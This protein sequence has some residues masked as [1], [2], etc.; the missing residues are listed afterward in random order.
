MPG[1]SGHAKEHK[2]YFGPFHVSFNIE[3]T[4]YGEFQILLPYTTSASIALMD[5]Y[6]VKSSMEGNMLD[7]VIPQFLRELHHVRS[8]PEGLILDPKMPHEEDSEPL[9]LD[10]H[11]IHKH[12]IMN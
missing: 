1:L 6:Q 4:Q 8:T 5:P 12:Y 11:V 3:I 9:T 2:P 10:G 7:G